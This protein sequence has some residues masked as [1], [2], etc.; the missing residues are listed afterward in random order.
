MIAVVGSDASRLHVVLEPEPGD[1]SGAGVPGGSEL[2]RRSFSVWSPDGLPLGELHP[3]L[4]ALSVFLVAQPWTT[5]RL[6][7]RGVDGVSHRLASAVARGYGLELSA[8]GD[9]APRDAPPGGRP[10]LAFSAGVDSTAAMVLMPPETPLVLLHRVRPGRAPVRD[11]R[12]VAARH[13]LATLARQGHETHVVDTDLEHVRVPTGFPTHWASA[14]P[15]VLL[16][17][18]LGLR[19]IS[20]G[21][22]LEAAYAVGGAG[23]FQ[24]W[25]RRSAVRKLVGVLAAVGLPVSPVV[26]GVSE[27]GTTRI[28]LGS[29]YAALA[30]SCVR[31]GLEPCDR[32]KKCFR[33]GLL[34]RALSSEEWTADHLERFYREE[35]VR[36]VLTRVPLDPGNVYGFLLAGYAGQD[37]VLTLLREQV[38]CDQVDHSLFARYFPPYL[39]RLP[40][41][42]RDH[43]RRVL[44]EHLGPMTSAEQDRLRAWRPV[45][46]EED[47]FAHQQLLTTLQAFDPPVAAGLRRLRGRL[48][49]RARLRR[50]LR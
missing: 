32:C 28:V 50:L 4:V 26:A 9:V 48:R 16:A 44:D 18:R 33:K 23:G 14:V 24:E 46:V 45:G 15:A 25:S 7:L 1:A 22:T 40:A 49:P 31:G 3:D 30:R 34:E 43:A 20:W 27:V 42:D 29:P 8:G 37:E 12:S 21:N 39:S 17:D 38:R 6:V 13:A 35:S 41:A 11:D 36:R 47:A 5:H 10:G 19:S 2:G